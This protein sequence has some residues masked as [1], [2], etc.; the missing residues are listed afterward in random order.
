MDDVLERAESWLGSFCE[1]L[2]HRLERT[3]RLVSALTAEV[4]ALRADV[5]WVL[6]NRA[7]L[8]VDEGPLGNGQRSITWCDLAGFPG[9]N[10]HDGTEASILRAVREARQK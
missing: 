4:R 1:G 9:E 7:Q 10:P 8:W 6:A 3:D 5:V 2:T